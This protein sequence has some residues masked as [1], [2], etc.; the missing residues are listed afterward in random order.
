VIRTID[1]TIEKRLASDE[2][3]LF[4]LARFSKKKERERK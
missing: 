2:V 1:W 4:S 3:G